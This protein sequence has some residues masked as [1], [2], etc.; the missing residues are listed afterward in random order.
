MHTSKITFK[1][2]QRRH[3][4]CTLLIHA[5]SSCS[6]FLGIRRLCPQQLVHTLTP[7]RPLLP[8]TYAKTT[9]V[10]LWLGL[11]C[12]NTHQLSLMPKD[13][14]SSAGHKIDQIFTRTILAKHHLWVL[15]NLISLKFFKTKTKL[16]EYHCTVED[17]AG[18]N[19]VRSFH[20][21]GQLGQ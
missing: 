8:H 14:Q 16:S 12:R 5:R 19:L 4:P 15:R 6:V 17:E 7:L 13:P 10:F 9:T 1:L 2:L 21:H 3:P 18:L 11:K 20:Q